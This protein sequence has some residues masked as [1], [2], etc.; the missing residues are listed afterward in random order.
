[1]NLK[2]MGKDPDEER[3]HVDDNGNKFD[4]NQN[5]TLQLLST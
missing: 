5:K 1:M 4:Q 3:R 2:G